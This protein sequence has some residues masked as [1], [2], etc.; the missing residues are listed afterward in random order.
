MPTR[1]DSDTS[2]EAP[3]LRVASLPGD[4]Q[5]VALT[6]HWTT[7]G[8]KERALSLKRQ[9][10]Q[11]AA[12]RAVSWD[13]SRV[14]KLDRTGALLL[15]RAWGRSFPE[16][17]LI[18]AVLKEYF[19]RLP[20]GVA[21]VAQRRF[22][23]RDLAQPVVRLGE[24]LLSV[25]DQLREMVWLIGRVLLD[26]VNL[27]RHPKRWPWREISAGI[28]RSGAQAMGILALVG[29]LIGVVL[30]YLSGDQLRRFGAEM[31]VVDLLGI[32]CV[33]ELGPL[34]AA[35]LVAGRSGSSITAQLGVMRLNEELD[36]LTTIG[37]PYTQRLIFPKVVALAMSQP[38]VG[39][40]T[41]AIALLGGMV[42]AHLT[43]DVGYYYFLDALP[44]VVPI[45]N[46][47]IGLGKGVVFGMIIAL[48]ACHFGLRVKPNTESLG[49]GTTSSVV[50]AISSVLVADAV[51]A[52]LFAHVGM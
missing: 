19:T 46:Y 45:A 33:R 47:W 23:R 36:A 18:P 20:S 43:L 2:G 29:F 39:L 26:C 3:A 21:E 35:I 37:I 40:W 32:A 8:L 44:R 49:A 42:A 38:L 10:M 1:R 15:W 16:S 22:Q 25:I 7:L 28:Y 27:A 6:G 12:R 9:L 4:T 34:L 11:H 14:E 41:S 24:G 17:L 31:Y 50:V 48:V 51:F 5:A 13:L 52:V 30:S